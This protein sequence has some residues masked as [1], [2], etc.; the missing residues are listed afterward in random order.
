[1]PTDETWA[2]SGYAWRRIDADPRPSPREET[3][4]VFDR[5]RGVHWLYGGLQRN[6]GLRSD[7]WRFDGERWE[8]VAADNPPGGRRGAEM[9]FDERRG[10]VV[11]YGNFDAPN[12]HAGVTWEWDG[13]RWIAHPTNVQPETDRGGTRLA[14]DPDHEVTW[15]FGGAPYG[16]AERADLW[17]WGEDPDG[18]GIVGGLDN[19]REA[20]NP[21]QLDGDGDAHGDACD[22]APGDAGAFALPSEVT[23]VR[24][25]GDGVTLSWDSAAPGAG[26]A[27][28]H[29]V[30]RG[31]ARELP[32]TD[33][34]DCLAR[35]VPGESLED[36]E[37]PPVGEAFWYVVRGRNACG[38]GPLGGERSSGACD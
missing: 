9:A 17:A 22:C 16:D 3:A 13:A 35:G 8:L 11:L 21:D 4:M 37:R 28:V 26:S 32:A 24:F 10:R 12:P 29:D 34:A 18:D 15:L 7:L 6:I 36:P 5:E 20:V 14:W 33:L 27:T 1:G 23:G 31:P 19:C 2:L 38:A 30:L 25:A